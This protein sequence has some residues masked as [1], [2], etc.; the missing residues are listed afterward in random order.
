[1]EGKGQQLKGKYDGEREKIGCL[2]FVSCVQDQC[3]LPGRAI[4]LPGC[5]SRTSAPSEK[6]ADSNHP[7]KTWKERGIWKKSNQFE[8]RVSQ[9]RARLSALQDSEKEGD[10]QRETEREHNMEL[11]LEH[12]STNARL[13]TA[14]VFTLGC[15]VGENS[16]VYPGR[17]VSAVNNCRLRWHP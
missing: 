6:R 1:M 8:E 9:R 11:T 16:S 3:A 14:R 4:H 12:Q 5:T 17:A 2:V 15:E 10:R 13:Q 7:Q